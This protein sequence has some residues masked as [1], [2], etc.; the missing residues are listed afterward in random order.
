M[1]TITCDHCGGDL[2][3]TTN[4]VAYRLALKLESIPR[5]AGVV[6]LMEVYPPIKRDMTFCGKKCLSGW[7]EDHQSLPLRSRENGYPNE[8]GEEDG[9]F[10]F[11]AYEAARVNMPAVFEAIAKVRGSCT[12]VAGSLP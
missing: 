9:P 4:C 6:T 10:D 2:T 12:R 5:K 11:E 3:P 7:L 1:N 8:F